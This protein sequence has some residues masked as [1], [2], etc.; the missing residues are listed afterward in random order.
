MSPIDF[1]IAF[2]LFMGVI[3]VVTGLRRGSQQNESSS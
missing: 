1:A 3:F 2:G